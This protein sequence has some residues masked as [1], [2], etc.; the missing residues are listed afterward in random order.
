MLVIKDITESQKMDR[1][2]MADVSGGV[3]QK[4]GLYP[5]KPGDV[6][7]ELYVDGIY[8]GTDYANPAD[9]KNSIYR[10]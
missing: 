5:R 9:M 10:V 1:D 8:I 7:Y 6:E 3:L 4:E 2:A